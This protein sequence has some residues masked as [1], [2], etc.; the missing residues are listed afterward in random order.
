MSRARPDNTV[1]V[2]GALPSGS[3]A[4]AAPE[5]RAPA[6]PRTFLRRRLVAADIVALSLS[7]LIVQSVGGTS[8][9]GM[10]GL[11]GELLIFFAMLPCWVGFAKLYGLYE[12][13]SRRADHS[14]VDELIGVFTVVTVGVWFF[15]LAARVSGLL[16]PDLAKVAAFWGATLVLI[17]LARVSVRAL[18]RRQHPYRQNALIVGAGTIGQLVA[19]KCNQHPEYGI[20]VVGFL[21]AEPR[22]QRSDLDQMSVLGSMEELLEVV[23]RLHVD[24]VV[25]AFSRDPHEETIAAIRALKR[26]RVQVDI[27]PRLF[28]V[29]GPNADLHTIEGIPLV[30]IPPVVISRSQLAVKRVIDIAGASAAL[31]LTAPLLLALALWIRLDSPGGAFFRQ[32]RLGR[33]ME[34]FTLLK[35]RTM[36]VG[37]SDAEHRDYIRA[38]M[39]NGSVPQATGLFKLERVDSVTRAG[40]FLRRVSLDELPQLINVLKGDMSLVGPRP[41]LAYEVEH[42]SPHHF[43]RFLVPA[44]I[45]GLWQVSARA[46]STFREALDMDVSYVRSFSIGLDLKLLLKTPARLIRR[47]TR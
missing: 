8:T 45:T 5:L 11:G 23:D 28:E 35:F 36:T 19:R 12:Y 24:R 41:C 42:F 43:E 21:D 34:P 40:A 9:D 33:N 2:G 46:H 20:N 17:V 14:T 44:G 3:A 47:G 7:F 22:E 27:V 16:V 6:T 10:V 4:L 15:A 1:V 32:E 30:G 31:L 37:T 13:D 38:L 25:F 39:S 26:F 29:V 18:Y